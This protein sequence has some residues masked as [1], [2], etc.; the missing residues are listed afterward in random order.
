MLV[1]EING[2][3]TRVNKVLSNHGLAQLTVPTITSGTTLSY[4]TIND[5]KNGINTK[6]TDE[7]LKALTYTTLSTT[8]QYDKTL[9]TDKAAIESNVATL[10][11]AICRNKFTNSNGNNSYGADSNGKYENGTCSY[12]TNYNGT[13]PDGTCSYSSNSNGKYDNGSNSYGTKS[14]SSNSNGK[15]DNGSN[16]YVDKS[17]GTCSYSTNS[18]GNNG[19]GTCP[20]GTNSNG[21]KSNGTYSNGICKNVTIVDVKNSN[22]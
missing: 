14:Y 2:W 21:D 18:N 6:K 19:N 1:T 10:E 9:A 20:Y 3:Y 11:T 13:C 16:S 12:S 8:S 15:Y 4:T 17:N 22:K 7:Y 5:L